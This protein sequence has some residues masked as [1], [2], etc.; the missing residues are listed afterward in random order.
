MLNNP[1]E[2]FFQVYLVLNPFLTFQ[3][4]CSTHS[5]AFYSKKFFLTFIKYLSSKMEG[6][7]YSV[8]KLVL[9]NI[10]NIQWAINKLFSKM[11]KFKEPIHSLFLFWPEPLASPSIHFQSAIDYVQVSQFTVVSWGH[12]VEQC[13]CVLPTHFVS[14]PESII[15]IWI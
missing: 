7:L 15:I 6:N 11:M 3:N 8:I 10:L 2:I 9:L 1:Q 12:E 14:K 5:F 13:W 4:Q